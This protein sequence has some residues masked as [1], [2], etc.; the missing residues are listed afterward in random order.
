M[1]DLWASWVEKYP[2]ISIEDAW[3]RTTGKA[4]RCSPTASAKMVQIVGDDL[5]VTNTDG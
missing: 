3:Q 4:G 5:F 1:V 2:I